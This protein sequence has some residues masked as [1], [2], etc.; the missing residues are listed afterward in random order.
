MKP[1]IDFIKQLVFLIGFSLVLILIGFFIGKE[2][3]KNQSEQSIIPQK[4]IQYHEKRDSINAVIKRIPFYYTDS[5]RS[6][7]LRNYSKYR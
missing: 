2:Y 1:N 6:E 7:V 3:A 4:D 5:A